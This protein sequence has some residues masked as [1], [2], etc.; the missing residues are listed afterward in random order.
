MIPTFLEGPQRSALL[1]RFFEDCHTQRWD[2]SGQ[3]FFL[4]WI[5]DFFGQDLM[6]PVGKKK[7]KRGWPGCPGLRHVS[8]G[9]SL[10]PMPKTE[11]FRLALSP[12][13]HIVT[14][15]TTKNVFYYV[16]HS[17][18]ASSQG[19]TVADPRSP[20]PYWRRSYG[21]RHAITIGVL[22]GAPVLHLQVII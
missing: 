5:T 22:R 14:R 8:S 3:S 10:P 18:T 13:L 4:F 6:S 2:R 15:V 20:P 16:I 11:D 21:V 17:P 19:S 7:K 12:P 9:N 1:D